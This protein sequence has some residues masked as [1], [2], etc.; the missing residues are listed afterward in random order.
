MRVLFQMSAADSSTLIDSPAASRLGPNRAFFSSE[1]G[2]LEKFRPYGVP[3]PAFVDELAT[4]WRVQ[5]D[6]VGET[7]ALAD[8]S[9]G[10]GVQVE[11]PVSPRSPDGYGPVEQDLN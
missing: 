1:E 5:P 9:E 3:S 4:R 7:S 11:R 2:R 8:Q 6:S 10:A